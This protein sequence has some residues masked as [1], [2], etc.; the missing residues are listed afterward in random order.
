LVTVNCVARHYFLGP[1][2]RLRLL[3]LPEE[4]QSDC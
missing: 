2:D 4:P 3:L 1:A